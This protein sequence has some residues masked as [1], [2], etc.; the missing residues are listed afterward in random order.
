MF[1]ERLGSYGVEM[2]GGEQKL[3][4]CVGKADAGGKAK[5]KPVRPRG[6]A[7]LHAL[8]GPDQLEQDAGI[9][10]HRGMGDAIGSQAAVQLDVPRADQPGLDH[11]QDHPRKE[12]QA[13]QVHDRRSGRERARRQR[14]Q[15]GHAET[16]EDEE[17]HGQGHP[18]EERRPELAG[19]FG[20][21]SGGR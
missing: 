17:A 6:V 15:I 18:E 9:D 20:I 1:R 2:M 12:Q 10:D 21:Y 8:P 14:K 3:A 5:V 11:E 4:A 19:S 7:H 16:A 13:V